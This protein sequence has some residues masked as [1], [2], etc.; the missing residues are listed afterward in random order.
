MGRQLLALL[1]LSSAIAIPARL[2]GASS[3]IELSGGWLKQTTATATTEIPAAR[4]RPLAP[5][6]L[7]ELGPIAAPLSASTVAPEPR[8]PPTRTA[9]APPAVDTVVVAAPAGA[10][11]A[12]PEPIRSAGAA[13]ETYRTGNVVRIALPRN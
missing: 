12:L 3:R 13:W 2:E 8:L 11:S 5:G 1:A 4:V 6:E 10:V 7:L 9:A